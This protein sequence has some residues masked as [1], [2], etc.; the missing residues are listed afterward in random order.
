MA[1]ASRVTTSITIAPPAPAIVTVSDDDLRD[2]PLSY[3]TLPSA[4][5][6]RSA[7]EA[8]ASRAP[9]PLERDV[10][11]REII[12]L[13]DLPATAPMAGPSDRAPWRSS[14]RRSARTSMAAR[15]VDPPASP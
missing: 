6:P 7:A 9:G 10:G 12:Q 1:V 14:G 15:R 8:R 4:Q 3:H 2:S 13:P 11:Q 5:R